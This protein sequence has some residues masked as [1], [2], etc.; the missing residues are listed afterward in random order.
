VASKDKQLI[1]KVALQQSGRLSVKNSG[2][3]LRT[4]DIAL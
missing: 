4:W 1:N 2:S 3:V